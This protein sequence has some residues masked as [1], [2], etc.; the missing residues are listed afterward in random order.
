MQKRYTVLT[1]LIIMLVSIF[2]VHAAD[3]VV[4][5]GTV[6]TDSNQALPTGYKVEIS[7]SDLSVT[8]EIER[9]TGRYLIPVQRGDFLTSF[10]AG[11]EIQIK[12]LDADGLSLSKITPVM[13]Q[14]HI[15]GEADKTKVFIDL[16]ETKVVIPPQAPVKAFC[17]N[18][19]VRT[20]EGYPVTTEYTVKFLNSRTGQE[21]TEQVNIDTGEYTITFIDITA[22]GPEIMKGDE[23]TLTVLDS[24]SCR[25]ILVFDKYTLSNTDLANSYRVGLDLWLVE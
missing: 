8:R 3:D 4:F 11:E 21:S 10:K 7:F 25:Q 6:L 2:I 17:F 1:L 22:D 14:I 19:L 12:V 18:G 9:D 5:R 16:P 24:A 20:G 15:L 13:K 23:F